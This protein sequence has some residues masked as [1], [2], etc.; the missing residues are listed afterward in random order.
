MVVSEDP[1]YVSRDFEDDVEEMDGLGQGQGNEDDGGEPKDEIDN[2]EVSTS[3]VHKPLPPAV[4]DT[5][6]K[7]LHFLK[8]TACCHPQ[9]IYDTLITF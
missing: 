4:H 7:H 1:N 2:K 8:E 6:Q 9:S 3:Q 5:Y